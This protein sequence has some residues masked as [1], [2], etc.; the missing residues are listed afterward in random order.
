MVNSI[1]PFVQEAKPAQRNGFYD[2]V[3]SPPPIILQSIFSVIE[4]H[5]QK[6]MGTSYKDFSYSS[7]L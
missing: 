3:A 5:Y 1:I 4:K 6:N 7:N 2:V